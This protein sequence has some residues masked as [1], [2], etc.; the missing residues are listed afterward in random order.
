[1]SVPP[2]SP[3]QPKHLHPTMD[4]DPPHLLKQE[5]LPKQPRHWLP[6]P[7]KAVY[8]RLPAKAGAS[9]K[10]RKYHGSE[11]CSKLEAG[12]GASIFS[13]PPEERDEF[14]GPC[15]HCLKEE[16]EP[17]QQRKA[18]LAKLQSLEVALDSSWPEIEEL[19]RKLNAL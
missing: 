3:V 6:P 16:L 4:L 1:M 8:F 15:S 10:S 11:D 19:V 2:T 13:F 14:E 5:L 17:I 12:K 7:T 9:K 18:A